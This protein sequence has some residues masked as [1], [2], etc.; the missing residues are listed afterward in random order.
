MRQRQKKY[1]IWL[2]LLGMFLCGTFLEGC[3]QDSMNEENR[4][5]I[6]S[7]L[8]TVTEEAALEEKNDDMSSRLEVHFLDVGQGD[9]TFLF[10]DGY[11]MLIDAGNNDKGTTVWSYLKEQGVERL[12]Y[13]IGTHPD[14]DHIGGMDVVLYKFN[15]GTVFMPDAYNDTRTY[16]DVVQVMK[17]K[18]YPVTM[19][20]VGETYSL[21]E[22]SFTII[23]PN[24]DYGSDLND[25]SV[26]I[27]VEH[28]SNR[29]LFT[30]DAEETA[31]ADILA[32]G[33][34]IS[35]DVYKAG[36]HGSNTASTEEFLQEVNPAY[37]VISCGEG[38][39]YGHP[40]A[41]VL[42]R[43]RSMGIDVFRTDEQGTIVAVSDGEEIVWNCTPSESWQAGEPKGSSVKQE[44]T[45]GKDDFKGSAENED[46]VVYITETGEKYHREECSSLKDS[47][48][49][50]SLSEAKKAG[51][52]PCKKCA[53]PE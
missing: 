42:N 15:C 12:D 11:S 34:D 36:H 46:V 1:R 20:I 32:N 13:V 21:G 10:C 19:P 35:A 27:L 16:E 49:E 24:R 2:I 51:Y 31:E 8:E 50:T 4:A 6:N 52:E 44:E 22:A 41:E 9:A 26:G 53:P 14:A 29:F 7:E 48:I 37:A 5:E 43:F 23:A 39:S 17:E 38:N 3:V 47:K 18:D 25:A 33:Q 30:G 40:H 28:G 45:S